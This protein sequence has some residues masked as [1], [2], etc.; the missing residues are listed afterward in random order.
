MGASEV[1]LVF[2]NPTTQAFNPKQFEQV[3]RHHNKMSHK[4]EHYHFEV[5]SPI[6]QGRW[7]EFLECSTGRAF[8]AKR[9][10]ADHHRWVFLH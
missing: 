2:D 1:H 5:N 3:R 4:H 10:T 8:A 7:Q 9:S 6:P